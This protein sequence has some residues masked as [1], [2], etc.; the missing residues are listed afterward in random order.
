MQRL[1][2]LERSKI[3]ER[4]KVVLN[5]KF[6]LHRHS[7]TVVVSNPIIL[8][9]DDESSSGSVEEMEEDI[10]VDEPV[11]E[12]DDIDESVGTD[13]GGVPS[14]F[15]RDARLAAKLSPEYSGRTIWNRI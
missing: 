1:W 5:E 2:D 7:P 10:K 9:F 13:G 8:S 15:G 4:R 12:S 11:E 6:S 3:V 14:P